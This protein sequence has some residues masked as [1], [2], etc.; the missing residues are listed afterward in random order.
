MT[1]AEINE[2]LT[3]FIMGE[4]PPTT[5]QAVT[6]HL[7]YCVACQQ[8]YQWLTDINGKL[9]Q[10]QASI[11]TPPHLA[12][13][14]E[15]SLQQ[16]ILTGPEHIKNS[17]LS[18][19]TVGLFATAA[20]LLMATWGLG[21]SYQHYFGTQTKEQAP[22]VV[23]QWP[24]TMEDTSEQAPELFIDSA[25]TPLPQDQVLPQGKE[26]MKQIS[27]V[28][29]GG[30]QQGI[31]S[32]ISRS[33]PKTVPQGVGTAAVELPAEQQQSP[34]PEQKEVF[35]AATAMKT[36][37]TIQPEAVEQL[38]IQVGKQSLEIADQSLKSLLVQGINEA[39]P[40]EIVQREGNIPVSHTIHVTL[41]N[42]VVHTFHYSEQ[43]NLGYSETLFGNQPVIPGPTLQQVLTE[44]EE[45][46]TN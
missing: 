23:T 7:K 19:K 2:L 22:R 36:V 1:C 40:A 20:L 34:E 16:Q 15:Q 46:L 8:Q 4:L 6:E 39:C 38:K 9:H 32:T 31:G 45:L 11:E 33:A 13:R 41:D 37:A 21:D 26:L 44:D 27:R 5:H 30:E 35:L 18:K 42:G 3:E 17:W 43:T 24:E 28:G 10:W 14:W 29:N 25:V 12:Q